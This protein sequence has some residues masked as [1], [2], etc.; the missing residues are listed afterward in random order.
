[1]TSPQTCLA[2]QR[3]QKSIARVQRRAIGCRICDILWYEL[4]GYATKIVKQ[5]SHCWQQNSKAEESGALSKDNISFGPITG[6]THQTEFSA[7]YIPCAN[8]SLLG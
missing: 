3:C 2:G 7:C 8:N 1:M 4:V 5:S 6:K